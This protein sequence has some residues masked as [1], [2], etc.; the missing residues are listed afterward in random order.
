M[1]VLFVS[2]PPRQ[3]GV[4]SFGAATFDALSRS[5]RLQLTLLELPTTADP[6]Q[7]VRRVHELAPDVVLYNWHQYVMPWLT[8]DVLMRLRWELPFVQHVGLVHD[9]APPFPQMAAIIHSDPTFQE[10][11]REFRVRRLLPTVAERPAPQGIVVGSF[12][13]ASDRKGFQ[14]VVKQTCAEFETATVRLH[15]PAN[16]YGDPEG[17]EARRIADECK[18]LARPGITVEVTSDFKAPAQLIEWLAGNSINCFFYENWHKVSGVSSV[19]DYALAA[20]RPIAVTDCL[21]FRHLTQFCPSI[22]IEANSLRE[23]LAAGTKPLEPVL[24]DWTEANVIADYERIF[25]AVAKQHAANNLTSNRVLTP[26]DREALRPSVEELRSRCPD[27]MSR[28]YAQ[29]VFQNAFIFEQVKRAA[30]K[31]DE[32]VVIGGHEDPI[33]PALIQM[34]YKVRITDPDPRVDGLS[35]RDVWLDSLRTGQLYDIVICCSVIEHVEKDV[36]FVHHLYQVLKP[37]GVAFLTTDYYEDWEPGIVKPTPDVRLY[38]SERMRL[39]AAQL[40]EGSLL[41]PPTWGPQEPYFTFETARYSFCSLAFLKKQTPPVYESHTADQ[42]Q[43]V[44]QEY[45]HRIALRDLQ[46][47]A[48]VNC[49]KEQLARFDPMKEAGP[50]MIKLAGRAHRLTTRFPALRRRM[51]KILHLFKRQRSA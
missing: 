49:L 13:F 12:G 47:E 35:S 48:L 34:G 7:F 22:R 10:T 33:G 43:A 42:G 16:H 5:Q 8:A 30:R 11:P 3:C 19:L 41:D 4:H 45:E 1:K 50:M 14:R 51:K 23:V 2:T 15:M 24:H 38:S 36:E 46:H 25:D 32:M 18:A 26:A 20:R 31:N 40:P 39:L 21:M 17:A 27:I 9:E 28:K 37:G 29:A 6:E 44:V